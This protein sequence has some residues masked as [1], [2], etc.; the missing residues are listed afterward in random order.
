[1]CKKLSKKQEVMLK[2]S[3]F[4][5]EYEA[6]EKQKEEYYKVHT[7]EVSRTAILTLYHQQLYIDSLI[8]KICKLVEKLRSEGVAINNDTAI[9]VHKEYMK[10]IRKGL[11]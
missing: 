2:L 5:A 1:M 6:L 8:G 4:T 9:K 3:R 10:L 7:K 11:F